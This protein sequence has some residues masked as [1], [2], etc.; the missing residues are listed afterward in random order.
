[1]ALQNCDLAMALRSLEGPA[2]IR[3]PTYTP[4]DIPPQSPAI[5][6]ERVRPLGDPRLIHYLKS[7]RISPE[8]AS[9][10]CREV[11][12]KTHGDRLYFAVGF[13]NDGGGWELRN[14]RFKIST[15]PKT[16][17]TLSC[18]SDT[19]AVFEGFMDYLSYMSMRRERRPGTDAIVL[20]SVS[21][22]S[23]A[24]SAISS[25]QTVLTYLDNDA[26]GRR[27]TDEIRRQAEGCRVIDRSELYRE[28]NDLN[29]YWKANARN[30]S[31][32]IKR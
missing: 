2:A 29:D 31:V 16:I 7:R 5:E 24:M 23:K 11:Y 32:G 21:N 1:M 14:S 9:R 30:L 18:G 22:L 19:V 6:I 25:H 27:T 10:Y 15:S 4:R 13:R 17:S 8:V 12:Y 3:I 26:A 20:N 28:H